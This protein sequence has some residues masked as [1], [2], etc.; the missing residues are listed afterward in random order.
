MIR[1]C[2]TYTKTNVEESGGDWLQQN[3]EAW[4][5]RAYNKDPLRGSKETQGGAR[6]TR[7]DALH[8]AKNGKQENTEA[9]EGEKEIE[10]YNNQSH[11]ARGTT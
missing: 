7:I 4:R 5:Y 6:T 11:L 10:A 9:K 1:R 8:I 2:S 3:R